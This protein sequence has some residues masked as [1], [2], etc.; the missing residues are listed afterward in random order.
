M[1]TIL[2]LLFLLIFSIISLPL[3]LIVFILGK[4]NVEAK[5]KVTQ[6]IVVWALNGILFIAGVRKRVYGLENVPKNTPVLYVANHRSYFD[7]V[8]GYT[9]V[10]TITSFISKKGLAKVPCI[11]HWMKLLKCLFLD[12]EDIKQGLQTILQGI[13]QMKDGY[14]I[15]IMPEGTRNHTDELLPFHEGSFKFAQKTGFPIVPVVMTHTDDIWEKHMPWIRKATV[16]IY[17]G[18]P[19]YV[20]ELSKEEKKFIGSYTQNIIKENLE[21]LK[22]GMIE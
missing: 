5:K 10:P 11:S 17:F 19:I 3:Y 4:F 22:S 9:T 18:K 14:S 7:I 16:S 8:V 21:K 1:K 6:K 20:N 2:I 15:F 12:R 13:D